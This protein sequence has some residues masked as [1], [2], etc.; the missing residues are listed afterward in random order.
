M[1]EGEEG[2]RKYAAVNVWFRENMWGF[3]ACVGVWMTG[4]VGTVGGQLSG[5]SVAD[6]KILVLLVCVDT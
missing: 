4:V 6:L 5:V 1:G 2:G 3:R